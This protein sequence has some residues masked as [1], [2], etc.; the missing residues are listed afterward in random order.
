MEEITKVIA[1]VKYIAIEDLFHSVKKLVKGGIST[2]SLLFFIRSCFL[3]RVLNK[4]NG[5][6]NGANY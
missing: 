6:L 1:I 5:T 4:R 2:I 3:L